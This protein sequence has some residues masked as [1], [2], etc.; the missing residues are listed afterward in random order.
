MITGTSSNGK[1]KKGP[2]KGTGKQASKGNSGEK[3]SGGKPVAV[4]Y[5]CGKAGHLARDCFAKKVRAVE[6]GQ[7]N[8]QDGSNNTQS[9]NQQRTQ[10]AV[11]RVLMQSSPPA[12]P[13]FLNFDLTQL[14]DFSRLSV[15]MVTADEVL[16]ETPEF[17]CGESKLLRSALP[18]GDFLEMPMRAGDGSDVGHIEYL[19]AKEGETDYFVLYDLFGCDD[20]DHFEQTVSAEFNF[21]LYDS[22][23]DRC[24]RSPNPVK[25][26]IH[27]MDPF[28]SSAN[29]LH[30]RTVH[31]QEQ[32]EI[33]LDSGSD[34]TV[35]PIDFFSA[36]KSVH[37]Q[38]QTCLRD[39]QGC[40]I[41]THGLREV[42]F[43]VL[44][45]SGET[46]KFKDRGYVSDTVSNPLLSYGKL[47][48]MGWCILST[49]NG[50]VLSHVQTGA[51][52]GVSF[53]NNS[54]VV[55]GH[56]RAVQA[57]KPKV[58][59]I[60]VS[61]DIPRNWQNLAIG[62][63]EIENDIHMHVGSGKRFI[64]V[65]KD[66]V[67]T[68]WPYRTTV[69]LTDRDG[70]RV[71]ELC[72]R[73]FDLK[74][75]GITEELPGKFSQALTFV[76]KRK[77]NAQDFGFAITS[78][79]PDASNLASSS[80]ARNS[81]AGDIPS[82]AQAKIDLPQA[83]VK[84]DER[85]SLHLAGIE[86]NRDSSISLL[87][88][89]CEYL[90]ISQSGSK[91]KLWK[92]ILTELDKRALLSDKTMV[93]IARSENQR[94]PQPVHVTEPP[95]DAAVIAA[96]NLTHFPY[97]D[98]CVACAE[99]KGRPDRHVEDSSRG[100][101]REYPIISSDYFYTGKSC[102][103]TDG[104]ADEASTMT[105]SSKL[106]ALVVHDSQTGAIHCCPA[107]SKG[108]FRYFAQ[109]ILRFMEFLGCVKPHFA[110]MVSPQL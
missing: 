29:L 95:A 59:A 22:L 9:V 66:Y 63:Y 3:G 76:T 83:V 65:T 104:P 108:H 48:R 49:A 80:G 56:I 2:P 8:A 55:H 90:Q 81:P 86:V 34:A 35:L 1:G 85:S 93:D 107:R 60:S 101:R 25:Q 62:W 19:C 109:E 75:S 67:V 110:A 102:K 32:Q 21:A 43:E 33:V 50:P 96:H 10:H 4:C 52:V 92:R 70:R 82:A 28:F 37:Q 36:G 84:P 20:A 42:T 71:V 14:A 23:D 41:E 69:A 99:A 78:V 51:Q 39:A 79:S 46:V 58:N 7:Q 24:T 17:D 30:V 57:E 45:L 94:Q 13:S 26:Y 88:A 38:A 72:E 11:Q 6:D 18:A 89:A 77:M 5:N 27:H 12:S 97:A 98:W 16:R 54:L 31:V 15:S 68:E 74:M 47:L 61:V 64:D 87:K 91:T 73:S 106:V 103:P 105:E 40:P 100:Q 53:R 44:T